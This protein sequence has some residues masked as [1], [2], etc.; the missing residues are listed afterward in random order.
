M[1]GF[2]FQDL[3][4]LFVMEKAVEDG[5]K[6]SKTGDKVTVDFTILNHD[7][8]LHVAGKRVKLQG[9]TGEVE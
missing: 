5:V 8:I 4:S 2:N 3:A 6:G 9:I 1:A 7:I